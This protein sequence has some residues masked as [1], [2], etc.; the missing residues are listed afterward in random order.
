[1]FAFPTD[2]GSGSWAPDKL[3]TLWNETPAAIVW[4]WPQHVNKLACSIAIKLLSMKTGIAFELSS[5]AEVWWLLFTFTSLLPLVSVLDKMP[6]P[7][8]C[9]RA[10]MVWPGQPLGLLW[11][12]TSSVIH[13]NW[14]L[15]FSPAWRHCTSIWNVP[16]SIAPY[17]SVMS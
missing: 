5:Q 9:T 16:S 14:V 4:G 6:A 3:G 17:P 7:S 13:V 15:Q 2:Q 1:M 12:L 8:L 11:P 10:G